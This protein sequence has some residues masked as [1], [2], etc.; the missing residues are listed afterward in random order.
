MVE[1]RVNPVS[2]DITD[3]QAKT[4]EDLEALRLRLVSYILLRTSMGS[5]TDAGAVQETTGQLSALRVP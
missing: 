5:L 3:H 2:K 1:S 4:R